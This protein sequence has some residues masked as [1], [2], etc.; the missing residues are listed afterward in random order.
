MNPKKNRK[1][2]I[3][4]LLFINSNYNISLNRAKKKVKQNAVIIDP[5][6]HKI[7]TFRRN[8][9]KYGSEIKIFIISS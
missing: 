7:K 2:N 4:L 8:L 9:N 6:Q 5:N 1:A 3:T